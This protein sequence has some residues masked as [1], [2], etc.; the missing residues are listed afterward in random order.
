MHTCTVAASRRQ[1]MVVVLCCVCEQRDARCCGVRHMCLCTSTW[2][3]CGLRTHGAMAWGGVGWGG[4]V[5]S[6]ALAL[7]ALPHM[8]PCSHCA[9]NT[10]HHRQDGGTALSEA[11]KYGREHVITALLTAGADVTPKV[12]GGGT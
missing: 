9:V 2:R 3:V 5:V 1:H 11:A 12:C 7:C 10:R 8:P 4:L 6:R